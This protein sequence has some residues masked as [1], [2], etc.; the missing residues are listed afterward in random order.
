M[1]PGRYNQSLNDLDIAVNTLFFSFFRERLL[2]LKTNGETIDVI[3]ILTHQVK[4]Y[5]FDNVILADEAS[6][7][8][9]VFLKQHLF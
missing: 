4:I 7:Q 6:L 5:L 8:K 3:N 2:T 1:G 9:R